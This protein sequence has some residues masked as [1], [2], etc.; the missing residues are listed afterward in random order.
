MSGIL[1][2]FW[3]RQ[4]PPTGAAIRAPIKAGGQVKQLNNVTGADN[5]AG[6]VAAYENIDPAND[7]NCSQRMAALHDLDAEIYN[8]FN[9]NPTPSLASLKGA[10]AMEKLMKKSEQAHEQLVEATKDDVN[11]VPFDTTNMTVKEVTDR[12]AVWRGLVD[13]TA[14]IK[15]DGSEKFQKQTRAKLA[16]MLQS[17]TG[18]D[19]LD[20]LGTSQNDPAGDSERTVLSDKMPQDVANIPHM[21][22]EH[23]DVSYANDLSANRNDKNIGGPVA[24]T[25]TENAIDFPT[26]IDSDGIQQAIFAHKKGYIL[27]GKKYTFGPGSGSFVT[28]VPPKAGDE[29]SDTA[30]DNGTQIPTPGF[31]TLGHELGHAVNI[32]AG[33]VTRLDTDL[34]TSVCQVQDPTITAPEVIDLWSNS[35]EYMVINNIENALREENGIPTRSSHK[36]LS[37]LKKMAVLKQLDIRAGQL[38]SRDTA[39]NDIP[40][41]SEFAVWLTQVKANANDPKVLAQIDKRLTRVEKLVSD[42]FIENHKVADLKERHGTLRDVYTTKQPLLLPPDNNPNGVNPLTQQY[43]VITLVINDKASLGLVC[44]VGTNAYQRMRDDIRI[45][46]GQLNNVV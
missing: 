2:N 29:H 30:G 26:L 9:T 16:K 8:W 25:G 10:K 21:A 27:A 33:S 5:I 43:N 7:Q 15:I 34:M 38:S 11:V 45:L 39:M 36:D 40:Q 41:V 18:F 32:R 4:P 23:Q 13:D 46:R 22:A 1:R 44:Q 42:G 6:L 35:E 31:V 24:A 17:K 20:Y 19:I 28:T 3:N 37:V 12:T 14:A